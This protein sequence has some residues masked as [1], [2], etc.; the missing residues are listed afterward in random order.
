VK[1]ATGL[2]GGAGLAYVVG[3]VSGDDIPSDPNAVGNQA[4]PFGAAA[5]DTSSACVAAQSVLATAGARPLDATD[6][7]N[8]ASVS[9][10]ACTSSQAVQIRVASGGDDA[11]EVSG[12]VKPARTAI[13]LGGGAG[14]M[15]AFR[16]TGA[17][18]PNR[19]RILSAKLKLYGKGFETQPI[20]IR[21]LGEKAAS[22]APLPQ[23]GTGLLTARAKTSSVVDDSPAA[24]TTKSFNA[25]PALT[26]ILQEI[27]DQPGWTS[28]NS[29]TLFV[30][31]NGS[32]AGSYRQV[33][34]FE[35]GGEATAAI[36]TVS[37]QP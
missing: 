10:P 22:S 19:A 37:Y 14:G 1:D 13:R 34:A 4:A 28:G 29:L 20:A 32:P 35:S 6:Q 17:V 8:L 7:Q 27:I 33:A 9:L 5:V 36:L 21:Y 11:E 12:Q 30:A 2:C 26:A 23:S 3:N 24:W 18:I 25:S 15:A 16:F 31:D